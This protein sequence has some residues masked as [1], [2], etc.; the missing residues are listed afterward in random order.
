MAVK[1]NIE[2]L[3]A[4][5]ID[6]A[7]EQLSLFEEAILALEKNPRDK[8]ALNTAFRS[9]H[10]IKG[11]GGI[12]KFDELIRF[13]HAIENLLDA[14]R[15]EVINVHNELVT[16]LLASYDHI[17]KLLDFYNAEASE[18]GL[19]RPVLVSNTLIVRTKQILAMGRAETDASEAFNIVIKTKPDLYKS[20]MAIE[21]SLGYLIRSGSV[22]S[23]R[24][25]PQN[26]PELSTYNLEVACLEIEVR[27]ASG[28]SQADAMAQLNDAFEFL[29]S[30]VEF[31]L[32]ETEP[33]ALEANAAGESHSRSKASKSIRVDSAKLDDFVNLVGE[34]VMKNSNLQQLVQQHQARELLRPVSEMSRLIERTRELAMNLRMVAIGPTFRKMERVVHDVAHESAKEV[35]LK[36]QGEETELD[37]NLIEKIS[38]PLVHIVRNS[39]D[40]GLESPAERERAGKPRVGSISLSALHQSGNII[41]EV[42]DDGRGLDYARI[43]DKAIERGLADA[44]RSYSNHEIQ[45]FIFSPGFS[46]AE[47]IS[48]ISGRGVGMD[49]VKKN[50]EAL[51]GS[52]RIHSEV[53][54]GMSIRIALPLTLAII[55][56][57]L[58]RT[59]T[60]KFIIPL[61]SIKECID[62][63]RRKS[64]DVSKDNQLHDLRGDALPYVRL[65]DVFR[66]P[67]T[68]EDFRESLVVVQH[69]EQRFGI[70]IDEPLGEYQ[71]VVKPLTGFL[72]GL[73]GVGGATI[74][75]GRD[76]ALILDILSLLDLI[77]AKRKKPL[78]NSKGDL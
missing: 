5:F 29:I 51:R 8:E 38:D 30:D 63:G 62:I 3:K 67:I 72:T 14:A 77:E 32:N 44:E 4:S 48:E 12:F 36:F 15:A 23:V 42:T 9:V 19:A 46:T 71:T 27:F 66:M 70:V 39:V 40:H 31:V 25:L 7:I 41:I 75:G 2:T 58:V 55:D 10:T 64:D 49:V 45:Q 74:L 18:A 56:G 60:Q 20:G 34:L 43:R 24:V 59:G 68:S 13:T 73:P 6:D 28:L 61:D 69:G 47:K 65:S 76:T 52:I 37:K 35:T 22:Q 21:E 11:S 1:V 33:T 50:I 53:G 78:A 26:L 57:F 54:S 17:K 16:V